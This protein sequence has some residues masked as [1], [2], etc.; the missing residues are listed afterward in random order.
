MWLWLTVFG[1]ADGDES[2]AKP[3]DADS[4]APE[5]CNN[6]DDDGDGEVDE[7]AIDATEWYVD[8]DGDG[9]GAGSPNCACVAPAGH[10]GGAGDCDDADADAY[11]GAPESCFDASKDLNC[12]GELAQGCGSEE[13]DLIVRGTLSAGVFGGDIDGDAASDMLFRWQ[14]DVLAAGEVR[15]YLGSEI[16]GSPEPDPL[17]EAFVLTGEWNGAGLGLDWI[18]D[19][20]GDE[21]DDFAVGDPYVYFDGRSKA[22]RIYFVTTTALTG[23]A[24]LADAGVMISGTAEEGYFGDHIA[25]LGDVDDDGVGD[26]AIADAS[27]M[28]ISIAVYSSAAMIARGREGLQSDYV[29][30]IFDD[31]D[32]LARAVAEVGD[33]DGDGFLEV[34]MACSTDSLASACVYSGSE[35]TRIKEW[36][37]STPTWQ[38][39]PAGG[40]DGGWPTPVGD[41]DGDGYGDVAVTAGW[42]YE[43][44]SI[45]ELCIFLGPGASGADVASTVTVTGTDPNDAMGDFYGDGVGVD[46]GTTPGDIDG[47][48]RDDLVFGAQYERSGFYGGGRAYFVDGTEL[49][50]LSVV[51]IDELSHWWE[52]GQDDAFYAVFAD[53]DL[54]ADGRP[55][56]GFGWHTRIVFG[57]D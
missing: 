22:G 51:T 14:E 17:S 7:D 5:T 33:L 41:L 12:D 56:F 48:G 26:L 46:V 31:W 52:G 15:V 35:L 23:D 43:E 28:P 55:D 45:P 19:I 24:K 32:Q 50:G 49:D 11:P 30:R 38:L 34:A 47:N 54:N 53:A 21:R 10:V 29:S 20:D 9:F 27:W 6:L 57:W 3:A 13:V 25:G 44:G 36:P 16:V 2:S 4:A 40:P 42:S 37:A 39:S 8:G 18:G 1:C